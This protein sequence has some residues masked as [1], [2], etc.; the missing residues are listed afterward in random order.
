MKKSKFILPLLCLGLVNTTFVSC[1]DDDDEEKPKVENN[2]SNPNNGGNDSKPNDGNNE[3]DPTGEQISGGKVLDK[4][5]YVDLG[6]S[7][8]WAQC[9]IGA[10]KPEQ[11]GS[12]FAWGETAAK[13]SFSWSNY[14]FCQGTEKTL[15]KYNSSSEY[16]VVDDFE[17]LEKAD[18]AAAVNWGGAWR[19]P[20]KKECEELINNT[21]NY[22]TSDYK[23]TKTAGYVFVSKD[24]K[25]ASD[26][27]F[28]PA[29]GGYAEKYLLDKNEWGNYW[30]ANSKGSWVDIFVFWNRSVYMNFTERCGGNNIRPVAD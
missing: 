9:N 3:S 15:T 16:G 24:A 22:W 13:S 30:V 27:L 4:H 11:A 25:Y 28:I 17:F 10:L 1:G 20:T 29:A 5:H 12:Y 19:M 23:S 2:D 21:L 14:K 8:K 26:T 7:V 6:L 18:D